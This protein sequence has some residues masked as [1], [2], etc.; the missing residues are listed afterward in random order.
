MPSSVID[1]LK[2]VGKGKTLSQDMVSSEAE[3][4]FRELLSG[5]FTAVQF[6]AFLQALRIKELTQVE[7]DALLTVLTENLQPPPPE[8]PAPQLV[9]NLASDTA[10]KG[11]LLSLAALGWL[12]GRGLSGFALRSDP[13][14]TGNVRSFEASWSLAKELEGSFPEAKRNLVGAG[15]LRDATC[16]DV[17]PGWARLNPWR[18]ELGFRSCLHTG[19]KLL[20]PYPACPLV[21]GISHRHYAERMATA[22]A[23][24]GLTGFV[25]L[26][27]HG[28]PDLV[29]HKPTEILHVAGGEGIRELAV[30][31]DALG[32]RAPSEIY[33][34]ARLGSWA[35]WMRSGEDGWWQ[36]LLGQ[37]AFLWYAAGRAESLEEAAAAVRGMRSRE[38][39]RQKE[40]GTES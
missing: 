32:F 25:V 22:L 33:S 11:G 20:N 37:A 29:L 35:E 27:N 36:G 26:G 24:R 38:G 2:K 31:L 5:A 19:E 10:R 15:N 12:A 3:T 13:V 9:L 34:L 28:T 7:L 8:S 39:S 16:S 17:L 1:T 30:D 23:G 14:L 18:S 4:A 40:R 21:L 6:G